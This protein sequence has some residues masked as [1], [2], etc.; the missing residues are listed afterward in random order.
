VQPNVIRVISGADDNTVTFSPA[1]ALGA[2]VTMAYAQWVGLEA[3]EDFLVAATGR[4]QVAQFLVGQSAHSTQ[5][6]F[7]GDP[8]IGILQLLR[9]EPTVRLSAVPLQVPCPSG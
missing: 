3:T 1:Q 2:Q 6:D 7:W 4:I 8:A 5:T 9:R